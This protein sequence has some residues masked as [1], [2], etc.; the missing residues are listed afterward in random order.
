MENQCNAYSVAKAAL[1]M[2][3]H[4][5]AAT[6]KYDG[7]A[8]AAIH[9]GWAQTELGDGI[10]EWMAKYAPEM[11]RFST[12]GAAENVVRV[13]EALTLEKTGAFWNFDGTDLP[14]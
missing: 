8:T 3:A 4:K 1:N 7:V 6:L 11:P 9:P 13:S 10:S 2:L 14:W 12:E 5:W